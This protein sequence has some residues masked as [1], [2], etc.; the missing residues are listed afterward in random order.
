LPLV[1]EVGPDQPGDV[2]ITTDE[3][4]AI[5]GGS[6]GSA[7]PYL[8]GDGSNRVWPYIERLGR[9]GL[10]VVLLH[11]ARLAVSLEARIELGVAGSVGVAAVGPLA[12]GP[13][14]GKTP[15]PLAMLIFDRHRVGYIMACATEFGPFVQGVIIPLVDRKVA[16]LMHKVDIKDIAHIGI[17]PG[18]V[19]VIR[20]RA[21][22]LRGV[23]GM[24]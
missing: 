8:A 2:G 14:N 10:A 7:Y 20:Q 13:L 19:V 1:I 6:D 18:C 11:M 3:V 9:P 15:D 21:E 4:V 23:D 24:G 22:A 12:I 17:N 16:L 5:E